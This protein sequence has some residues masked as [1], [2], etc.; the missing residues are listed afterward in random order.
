MSAKMTKYA[1]LLLSAGILCLTGCRSEIK[2]EKPIAPPP[3]KQPEKE[4][5]GKH[6]AA[7]S[8][9]PLETLA[10]VTSGISDNPAPR[11]RCLN[12]NKLIVPENGTGRFLSSDCFVTRWNILGPFIYDPE[13]NKAAGF[14]EVVHEPF[15]QEEK[16]LTGAE[17]T[18]NPN[19]GWQLARFESVNIPARLTCGSCLKTRSVMRRFTL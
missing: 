16:D 19:L 13:N 4:F 8:G 7:A 11:A 5:S 2:E 12:V 1:V 10:K 17:K 18:A 9:S 6:E 3:T 15:M 14:A